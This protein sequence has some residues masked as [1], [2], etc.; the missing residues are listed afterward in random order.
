MRLPVPGDA[1]AAD[2]L[3]AL[4]ARYAT[5]MLE[6]AVEREVDAIDAIV[7]PALGLDAGDIAFVQQQ[8]ACD[9]FLSRIRP[10]YPYFTPRQRGRRSRLERSTRYGAA[11]E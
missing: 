10:R 3:G 6:E 7:G 11:G 2:R 9:P 1:A 5:D 8:M 4:G